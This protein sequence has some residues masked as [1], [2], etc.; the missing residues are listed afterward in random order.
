MS[1]E[2]WILTED[3]LPEAEGT[4]VW[5]FFEY[6][7]VSAGAYLGLDD[8]M[9]LPGFGGHKGFLL[10]DVTHWQPR[11]DG[12]AAPLAPASVMRELPVDD[13]RRVRWAAAGGI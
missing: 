6:T 1:D 5:Y 4:S 3:R 9:G 11:V 8:M 12:E 10:G 13:P 7:G 2:R